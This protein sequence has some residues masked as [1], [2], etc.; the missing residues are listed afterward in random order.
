VDAL[1]VR[2]ERAFFEERVLPVDGIVYVLGDR[3]G[4][5]E[6]VAEAFRAARAVADAVVRARVVPGLIAGHVEV[7]AVDVQ[8]RDRLLDDP[9]GALLLIGPV[10]AHV[11]VAVLVDDPPVGAHVRPLGVALVECPANLREV[12]PGDHP[13]VRRMA[14]VDDLLEAGAV[15][16]PALGVELEQRPVAGDDARGVD[17]GDGGPEPPERLDVGGRVDVSHVDLAQVRLDQAP[18]PSLP[19][20]RRKVRCGR[21]HR[22]RSVLPRNRM[23]ARGAASWRR[24]KFVAYSASPARCSQKPGVSAG[25]VARCRRYAS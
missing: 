12:H 9:R 24:A 15:E 1:V 25:N 14:R 8:G 22:Q 21:P 23:P 19:P 13:D 16:E 6:H 11:N 17:H 3:Q 4:Q 2:A 7:D 5:A 10:D 18:R 20:A